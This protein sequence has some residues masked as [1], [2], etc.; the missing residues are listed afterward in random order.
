MK[1]LIKIQNVITSIKESDV[2]KL[3]RNDFSGYDYFTPEQIET[4]VSEEC[5]KEKL[6]YKFDLIRNDLGIYGRLSIYDLENEKS[7]P[8]VYEMASDIPSIK[9]TNIAQQLGGAMTY[10]KRY[11]LMNGF[12]ITDNNLDHDTTQNTQK[13]EEISITW[14]TKD[15]FESAMKSDV[16]GIGAT[17]EK[18]SSNTHKMKRDFK[19][20]LEN[21]L[22]NLI[23]ETEI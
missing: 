8:V 23:Q 6:F 11:L 14:L 16:K 4:I 7:E 1:T 18:Y 17:L 20:E 22:N 3:G 21:Q 13:R 19:S 15:Q 10:T 9:A 12:N 2:K 5:L